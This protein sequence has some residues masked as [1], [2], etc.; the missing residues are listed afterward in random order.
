MGRSVVFVYNPRQLQ[1]YSLLVD[2]SFTSFLSV[3]LH[4]CNT[5]TVGLSFAGRFF[6]SERWSLA[7]YL[8]KSLHI[9]CSIY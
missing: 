5:A 2:V 3:A 6:L 4:D 7:I 9:L 8:A 1:D